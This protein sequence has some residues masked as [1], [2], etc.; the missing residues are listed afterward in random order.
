MIRNSVDNNPEK[1]IIINIGVAP[2]IEIRPREAVAMLAK[3][4]RIAPD[5]ALAVPAASLNN[6]NVRALAFG[7]MI[8]KHP[9]YIVEPIKILIVLSNPKKIIIKVKAETVRAH[10]A[11]PKIT[12]LTENRSTSLVFK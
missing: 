9:K 4:K 3:L 6:A 2:P 7:L 12:I 5:T 10:S 11:P 8:P 1:H